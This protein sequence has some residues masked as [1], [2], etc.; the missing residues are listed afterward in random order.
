M[1]PGVH[2]CG[3]QLA[4][5]VIRVWWQADVR[6]ACGEGEV[7]LKGYQLVGVNFLLL[8]HRQGMGGGRRW[9]KGGC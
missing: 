4:V 2:M 8:L 7:N 9:G 5:R 1:L 6:A 3:S